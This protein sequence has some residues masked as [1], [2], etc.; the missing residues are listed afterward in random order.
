MSHT[1]FAFLS[2]LFLTA[3]SAFAA[4]V[5]LADIAP[6]SA[7]FGHVDLDKAAG[8]KLAPALCGKV[9]RNNPEV[10]SK[11]KELL[12][13]GINPVTDLHGFTVYG[14]GR[15]ENAVILIYHSIPGEKL[16]EIL[17]REAKPVECVVDGVTVLKIL[18]TGD[19]T[20]YLSIHGNGPVVIA[21]S[22]RAVAAAVKGL[23][24]KGIVPGA[25]WGAASAGRSPLFVMSARVDKLPLEKAQ[26]ARIK[27]MKSATFV[28]E[29]TGDNVSLVLR[30]TMTDSAA[31]EKSA[32][33]A[34]GLKSLAAAGIKDA[35]QA[36]LFAAVKVESTGPALTIGLPVPIKDVMKFVEKSVQVDATIVAEPKPVAAK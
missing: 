10:G 26:S 5:K 23:G 34:N 6:G 27:D 24:G 9:C 13:K 32:A 30:A 18:K 35:E 28:I 14:E 2:V 33:M 29:E 4:P 12:M 31:A 17:T 8:G 21:N 7:W 15:E 19:E 36:A 25:E 22:E 20:T 16:R 1:R 3:A 11:L